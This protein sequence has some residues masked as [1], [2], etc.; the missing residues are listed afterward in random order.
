MAEGRPVPVP[1]G[2]FEHEEPMPSNDR[3]LTP[4]QR[5]LVADQD[6]GASL[7]ASRRSVAE[8]FNVTVDRVRRVEREGLL[9]R[10]PCRVEW[11]L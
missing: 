5:R 6:L 4:A 10:R 9:G 3:P 8:R 2:L 11:G 1:R 7:V